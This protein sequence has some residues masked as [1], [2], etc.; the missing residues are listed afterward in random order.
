M[1]VQILDEAEQDLLEGAHFYEN[2]IA[3]RIKGIRSIFG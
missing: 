3:G 1:Q 2:Q